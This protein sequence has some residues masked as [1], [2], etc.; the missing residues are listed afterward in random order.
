MAAFIAALLNS[1]E[2]GLLLFLIASGLTIVFGVLGI[3][4]FAHG[5]LYMLGAYFGYSV[6]HYVDLPFWAAVIVVPLAVAALA[7][8]IERLTLRPIYG[9]HP[10]FGLLLTFALL[11]ILD[12]AVRLIWGAG[13]HIVDPP[14]LLKGTVSILGAVYPRYGFFIIVAAVA[15]G[16]AIWLLFTRTRVGKTVRAAAIDRETAEALGINVTALFTLVF[17][18]GAGLAALA[19]VLAAP[20]RAI[21]PSMGERIIIESF[22]V[23][24]IGG[25]GS[26]PGALVGALILGA[27]HGFGGRWLPE[28]NLILPFLGMAVVLLWR[29]QGLLGRSA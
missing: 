25:L 19:G 18:F 29:P 23:V 3:L 17:A 14:S 1:L 7:V 4:N 26:F 24:V 8:V 13:Y 9:R 5:A 27:I 22:I 2:F 28:L 21:G 11:L 10:T 6:L 16:V 12:D 20:I 15:I